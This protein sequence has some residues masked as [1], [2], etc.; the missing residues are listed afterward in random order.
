MITQLKSKFNIHINV[1]IFIQY[2]YVTKL[3]SLNYIGNQC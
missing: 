1:F 2:I 3:N